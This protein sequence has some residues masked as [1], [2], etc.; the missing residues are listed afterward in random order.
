MPASSGRNDTECARHLSRSSTESNFTYVRVHFA[1]WFPGCFHDRIFGLT[2]G[3]FKLS[4]HLLS[5]ALHLERSIASQL[6]RLRLTLPTTSSIVPF[7]RFLFIG[8]PPWVQLVQPSTKAPKYIFGASIKDD[9]GFCL[10]KGASRPDLRW[11]IGAPSAGLHSSVV[12]PFAQV[13]NGSC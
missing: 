11:R 3:I 4:L 5:H 10:L 6:A 12:R 1:P 9:A 13:G 8:P 2:Q 7:T